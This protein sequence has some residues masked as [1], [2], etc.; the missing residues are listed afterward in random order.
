MNAWLGICPHPGHYLERKLDSLP[1]MDSINIRRAVCAGQARD[2]DSL[3][4]TLDSNQNHH[5]ARKLR[6]PRPGPGPDYWAPGLPRAR[7]DKT[8][9][10]T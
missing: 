1:E 7:A 6:G 10:G 2:C 8:Q 5:D 3:G 9:T 4:A